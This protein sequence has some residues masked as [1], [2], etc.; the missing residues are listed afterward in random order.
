MG[1]VRQENRNENAT[2]GT[3]ILVT[4]PGSLRLVAD[5]ILSKV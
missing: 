1:T 4:V 3:G 5:K 2:F